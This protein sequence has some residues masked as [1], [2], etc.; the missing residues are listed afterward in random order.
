M[1]SAILHDD[2]E[3]FIPIHGFVSL[4]EREVRIVNHPA[5][6]RLA[7]ML[8]LGHSNLVFRG[9]T[10]TRF[11]HSIG[12]VH[13]TQQIVDAINSNHDRI[14]RKLQKHGEK[15]LPLLP[16]DKPL[17]DSELA[18]VRLAALT[19]DLGHLPFGHTLEDELVLLEKHDSTSRF[20][21]VLDRTSW[22]G[23]SVVTLRKIIDEEYRSLLSPP[24]TGI[25]PSILLSSI[26]CK[27]SAETSLTSK[28]FR[29]EVVRDIVGNTIC[30]DLLD[31]LYRDWFHVGKPIYV[32]YRLFQYF[33]IRF[34]IHTSKSSFCVA[35]GSRPKIR[36][37]AVSSILDLLELRYRLSESVLYHRTKCSAAACLE[38]GL[39]ELFGLDKLEK[40]SDL[41]TQLSE[42]KTKL[43]D[44]N[45]GT[46]LDS[47]YSSAKRE[48]IYAGILPL[49]ALAVGR[50]FKE[51]F[52]L[53]RSDMDQEERDRVSNLYFRSEDK[54]LIPVEGRQVSDQCINRINAMRLLEQDFELK[55]GSLV[56]YVPSTGM[57]FKLAEVNIRVDDVIENFYNWE[58]RSGNELSGGHLDAQ[59]S[60]FSN[61]WRMH[62]FIDRM[63]FE[64]LKL[65]NRLDVIRE[66][67]RSHVLG[68]RNESNFDS[69]TFSIA[70]KLATDLTQDVRQL[71]LIQKEVLLAN[72]GSPDLIELKYPTG[73]PVI[74]GYVNHLRKK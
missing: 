67:I 38:R 14:R 24:D 12:C 3:F 72:S 71:E 9:A 56:M 55:P 54:S 26:V 15:D 52:T 16:L 53:Y 35:L 58:K 60:R 2:Q 6:Q 5:F 22:K 42:L 50:P 4:T 27:D 74:S 37:D 73:A 21:E 63:A 49:E 43:L 70:R 68:I 36:T 69:K 64:E 1:S 33:E 41:Q 34:N 17:N 40:N 19:H 13:V 66:A 62:V 65:R 29:L 20:C 51:L 46:F 59:E 8:Q 61:L 10:H 57:G 48:K 7:G 39:V 44:M 30:A 32:D 25:S 28:S 11:E 18:F 45:D 47:V 31:Y 23:T